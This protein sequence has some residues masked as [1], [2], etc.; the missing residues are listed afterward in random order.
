[1]AERNL[2]AGVWVSGTSLPLPDKAFT[3]EMRKFLAPAWKNRLGRFWRLCAKKIRIW[4][5]INKLLNRRCFETF[6]VDE[7]LDPAKA[8][9]SRHLLPCKDINFYDIMREQAVKNGRA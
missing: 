7:P 9:P 4:R 8:D 3:D 6:E 2:N 1:M 5:L